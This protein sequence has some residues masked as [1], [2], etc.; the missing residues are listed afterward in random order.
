MEALRLFW[1][2]KSIHG[3]EHAIF[4]V[5]NLRNLLHAIYMCLLLPQIAS[6]NYFL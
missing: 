3:L 1:N 5:L 4:R 2:R 6:N